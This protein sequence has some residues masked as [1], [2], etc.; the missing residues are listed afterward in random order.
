M[1]I[2]VRNLSKRFEKYQAVRDV[3]FEVPAGELVALLGPSGSGKSTILRIIA[4][5]E[6]AD[7]GDVEITGEDANNLSTQQRGVGFV[8]Q[9]YALFRHMTIRQ[10]VAFGLQVQKPRPRAGEIKARVEELLELVQLLGHADRYPSQLS[11][12]Q[13]QRVALARALATRPKVLLLDEPFG[14]LDAKVREELRTWLRR[15]HD[16]VHVTSLFVT[17]DQQEA[18]EVADQVIV[19][20]KGRVEQMGP[21][22][23]LYEH[24]ATPF[25]TEFLGSV[26]VLR[27]ETVLGMELGDEE[28]LPLDVANSND[29]SAVYVRPHDFEITRQ[30]NGRPAWTARIRKLI[31]LGGLVRLDLTLLDGTTLNVQLTRERCLELALADGEDIYVSPKDWKVFHESKRFVE[32]YV[33]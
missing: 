10:N 26:N 5:L 28:P 2:A 7:S 27:A 12:G 13:R 19:L 6:P 16:E 24:P 14:A 30:S 32:N 11:G 8:F 20:N 33:I 22:Q 31:P 29:N 4:G 23:E 21:P 1:A 18:F 15:L 17:H 3:S 9:H 25:V